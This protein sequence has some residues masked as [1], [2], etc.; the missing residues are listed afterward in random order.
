M[1]VVLLY[2]MVADKIDQRIVTLF[3]ENYTIIIHA[4]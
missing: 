3:C 1:S 4:I 2:L